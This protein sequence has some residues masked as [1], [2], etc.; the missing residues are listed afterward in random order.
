MRR[1]GAELEGVEVGNAWALRPPGSPHTNWVVGDHPAIPAESLRHL[2]HGSHPSGG[3]RV[4][5]LALK[6]FAHQPSDPEAWGEDK[7]LSTGRTLS[8]LAGSG[9]FEICFVRDDQVMGVVLEE[10]GDYALWGV[11][12]GHRWRVLR[13]SLVVTLRWAIPTPDGEETYRSPR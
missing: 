4:E 13:P 9:E 12:I 2:R 10:P 8:L 5:D 1:W 11:G 3:Q 7:P 6:W